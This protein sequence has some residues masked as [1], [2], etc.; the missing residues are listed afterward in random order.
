MTVAVGRRIAGWDAGVPLNAVGV[1]QVETLG[2]VL[3]PAPLAAVISSPLERAAMTAAAIAKP[4]GLE[5]S[6]REGLG[7]VRFGEWTGWTLEQLDQDERWKRWCT[8]RATQRAPGG[9]T[10]LETQARMFDELMLAAGTY[11]DATVALVSHADAIRSLLHHLLGISLDLFPRLRIDPASV[12]VV[13][14]APEKVEVSGVNL[15]AGG[16]LESLKRGL[17]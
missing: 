15:R 8:M 3:A 1:T 6:Y 16:I 13:R 14:L 10:M 7:E 4:H 12:S 9:E 5:V 2:E 17:V 11:P